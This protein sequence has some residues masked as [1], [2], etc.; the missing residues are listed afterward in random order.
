MRTR[1]RSLDR[2]LALGAPALLVALALGVPALAQTP[3]E[4]SVPPS[5]GAAQPSP[6]AT[7][8]PQARRR[9]LIARVSGRV[10]YKPQ[11]TRRYRPLRE[12]VDL[13]FGASV[14]ARAGRVRITI[15]RSSSGARNSAVFYSGKFTLE[16]QAGSPLVTTLRLTGSS[17]KEACEPTARAARVPADGGSRGRVRRLWGDGRG[18]FRTRGRYSAATVRGTKWLTE[19]R[20][21]GTLTRVDRGEVEVEDF[22]VD[23]APAPVREPTSPQDGGAGEDGAGGGQAPAAAPAPASGGTGRSRRVR[24]QRGA[25]YVA[26]PR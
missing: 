12:P 16:S 22:T 17:F 8:G 19:D 14:D 21:E 23:E 1:F 3:A 4:Y 13:A 25:S 5:S 24:V 15:E 2:R 18:R 20:C 26:G 11:G 7:T 9:A 10:L 6:P